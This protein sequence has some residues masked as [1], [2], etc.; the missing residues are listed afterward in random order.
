M[1]ADIPV[2][3]VIALAL[4]TV[5]LLFGLMAIRLPST[6]VA[7]VCEGT[8]HGGFAFAGLVVLYFVVPRFKRLFEDFGTELPAMTK[9]VIGISDLTVNYW[10]ILLFL[11]LVA[12][13]IDVLAFVA[14]HRHPENRFVARIFSAGITFLLLAQGMIGAGALAISLARVL[15]TLS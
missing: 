11:L 8:A 3:A 14:F 5:L 7:A 1:P 15:D 6:P 4:A 13:A 12:T 9:W 10:Y 2:V